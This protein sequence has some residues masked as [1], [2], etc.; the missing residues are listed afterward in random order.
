MLVGNSAADEPPQVRTQV[1]P[2]RIGCGLSRHHGISLGLEPRD[3]ASLWRTRSCRVAAAIRRATAHRHA[4]RRRGGTAG[5]CAAWRGATAC[6][7]ATRRLVAGFAGCGLHD[8]API[9]SRT[10]RLNVSRFRT[11]RRSRSKKDAKI[12]WMAMLSRSWSADR[13]CSV[14][15]DT[16]SAGDRVSE[17]IPHARSLCREKYRRTP[18]VNVTKILPGAC[19]DDPHLTI[20]PGMFSLRSLNRVVAETSKPNSHSWCPARMSFYF[21]TGEA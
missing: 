16:P 2:D 6:R 3:S 11:N 20:D 17:S 18:V 9:H 14:A 12:W 8:S 1:R 13:S 19:D 7:G 21:L 4:A 5:R 15:H 10:S